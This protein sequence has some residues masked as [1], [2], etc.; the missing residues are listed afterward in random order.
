MAT[1][2]RRGFVATVVFVRSLGTVVL[3][4]VLF[5]CG[6]GSSNDG[7]GVVLTPQSPAG[8]WQGTV[9]GGLSGDI[10]CIIAEDASVYCIVTY[11]GGA[12]TAVLS[13]FANVMLSRI[14]L[15]GDALGLGAGGFSLSGTVLKRNS[16]NL[17]GQIGQQSGLTISAMYD[18]LYDAGSSLSLVQGIYGNAAW[19]G[20]P[21]AFSIDAN[22]ALFLQAASGCVW[23]GEVSIIDQLHDAYRVAVTLGNCG[24]LDGG[25]LG[26]ATYASATGNLKMIAA[27]PTSSVVLSVS[28]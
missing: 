28:R 13:G 10:T 8:V 27:N 17:A 2:Q 18:T 16:L 23:T 14:S 6:G 3:A 20:S 21:A 4:A 15:N 11:A 24:A 19:D 25:Y 5:G 7:P 1:L 26:L 12:S 22:G 9:S